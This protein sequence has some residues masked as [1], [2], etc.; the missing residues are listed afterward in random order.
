MS[1]CT[2]LQRK[3]CATLDETLKTFDRTSVRTFFVLFALVRFFTVSAG[4][5][6]VP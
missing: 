2:S 4:G 5:L 3:V 6:P 1:V